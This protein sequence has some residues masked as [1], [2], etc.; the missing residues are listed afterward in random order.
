M[1]DSVVRTCLCTAS[2]LLTLLWVDM[3]AETSCLDCSELTCIDTSLAKT[4][5]TVLS[6]CVAWNRTILTCWTDYLDDIAVIICAWCF[7][8]CKSDTLTDDFSLLVDT[9]TELRCR[10]RNQCNG[11][12]SLISSRLPANAAF[13]TSSKTACLILITFSSAYILSPFP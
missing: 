7:T 13:A 12:S 2:T 1:S 11:M 6:N 8:L 3:W 10:S 5:L 9:A 4:V